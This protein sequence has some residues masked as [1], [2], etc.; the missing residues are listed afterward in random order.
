M[1]KS[2]HTIHIFG[3][4]T[5]ALL[6]HILGRS[7]VGFCL[8]CYKG[9]GEKRTQGA[10]NAC[11]IDFKRHFHPQE[12]K[13]KLACGYISIMEKLNNFVLE[14]KNAHPFSVSAFSCH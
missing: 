13:K 6:N 2:Q 7:G 11:S 12:I 8:E 1:S 4:I 10:K 9:N 3:P 14:L 5:L